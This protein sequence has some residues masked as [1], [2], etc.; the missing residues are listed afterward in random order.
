VGRRDDGVTSVIEN[1]W[2]KLSSFTLNC[3]DQ[4]RSIRPQAKRASEAG[5][6]TDSAAARSNEP[7]GAR[8]KHLRCSYS[9]KSGG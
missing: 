8:Q 9:R 1:G 2:T 4:S 6:Y 3:A 5:R 7:S